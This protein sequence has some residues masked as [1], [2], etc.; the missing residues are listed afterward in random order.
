VETPLPSAGVAASPK[1]PEKAPNSV[2]AEDEP[3]AFPVRAVAASASAPT[4][5]A[6]AT[7]PAELGRRPLRAVPRHLLPAAPSAHVDPGAESDEETRL[8]ARVPPVREFPEERALTEVD[9]DDPG[10]SHR[11]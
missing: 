1:S 5:A 8:S 11:K 4:T 7:K 10:L 2:H 9:L 6:T 3:R